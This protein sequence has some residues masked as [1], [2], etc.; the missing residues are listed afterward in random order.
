MTRS[1]ALNIANAAGAPVSPEH[2]RFRTLLDKIDKARLRLQQWQEQLPLFA[3]QYKA[4]VEP[5]EQ[6]LLAQRRAWAF[7][8]ETLL[9]GQR[10]NKS[11][12]K[13]LSRLMLDTCTDLF[14]A[15]KSVDDEL[16]ALYNR[17]AEVD[18]DTEEQ[19]ELNAMKFMLERM[20]DLDLG[21]DPAAS[22]EE[23]L[24]R[25]HE[26]M[27]QRE[28]AEREQHAA[29]EQQRAQHQRPGRRPSGK[30]AAA[31]K[32]AEEDARQASQTVREVYR[33]LAAALHPDRTDVNAP[34]EQ[35]AER[36]ALMQRANGAYEAGDLLALLT[37]QLQIEQVNVAQAAQLA[38][39]QVRHFNKVLGEQLREIE[40]EIDGRQSA[41]E[42]SY[43]ILL[44]QRLDPAQLGR[45]LKDE[46]RSVEA[47]AVQLANQRRLLAGEPVQAKRYLKRLR[48]EQQMDNEFGDL[49]F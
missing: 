42:A 14:A 40:Q 32:R 19:E 25:A 36:T 13:T 15:S 16:K 20:G 17:H 35:R 4:R 48:Q 8:L 11:E 38:T 22:T 46:M 27:A 1:T 28:A 6:R 5:E 18:F 43:G 30:Q 41:F 10:W 23:L 7:E 49:F 26:Q 44:E 24:Q 45:L 31:Q 12:T 34:A 33:K 2:K 47:A 9:L 37:L 39:S 21:D 3:E 29:R